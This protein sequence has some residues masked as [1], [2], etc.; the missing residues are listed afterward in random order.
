MSGRELLKAALMDARG[1]LDGVILYP[2][3][4]YGLDN[5]AA[6]II[7]AYLREALPQVDLSL[8]R[9][10]QK[11]NHSKKHID[12]IYGPL[13][14][15]QSETDPNAVIISAPGFSIDRQSG[16]LSIGKQCGQFASGGTF[17]YFKE[18][19]GWKKIAQVRS[20]IT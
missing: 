2:W 17:I 8:I 6:R 5:E 10:F 15:E 13:D 1:S 14:Y 3:R 11:Q 16:M 9:D 19:T 12:E 7:K 18:S 4:R 20:W